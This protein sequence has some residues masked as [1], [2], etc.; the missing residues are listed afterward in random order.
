[1][2]K[3]LT[4]FL[5]SGL[6]LAGCHEVENSKEETIMN[7]TNTNATIY[8]NRQQLIVLKKK[9]PGFYDYLS[10]DQEKN[11]VIPGLLKTKT[12]K[13]GR[14]S[15]SEEM[16]PQ[17]V[18]VAG[19]YL[20]VS[21]YSRDHQHNSVLYVLDR[22]TRNYVKTIVLEGQPHVGGITFDPIHSN[23]WITTVNENK[24]KQV[25]SAQISA[26]SLEE[27]ER[28]DF[29]STKRPIHYKFQVNLGELPEASFVGYSN[30]RLYIGLFEVDQEGVLARYS[31]EKDGSIGL[32]FN[33]Q[34]KVLA[35]HYLPQPERL[36]TLP[37]KIQGIAFYDDKIVLS[38][39]YGKANSKLLVYD[40]PE[41][42]NKLDLDDHP[43]KTIIA[44]PYMEQIT[45]Y[46]GKLYLIFESA[47][48]K[49]RKD[50]T[51][52]HVD[53]VLELNAKK[54]LKQPKGK[55][56]AIHEKTKRN[57]KLSKHETKKKKKSVK[58]KKGER[59]EIKR[60][61]WKKTTKRQVS[62]EK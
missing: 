59:T 38:Q 43:V 49:Y 50:K 52:T 19:E 31:I 16:D 40:D 54:T 42:K 3:Y 46:Q 30:E 20:I 26:I 53:R 56:P 57:Q 22:K 29:S 58:Y 18:G 2:K 34:V 33:H 55:K 62:Y 13:N 60:K 28:Y 5:L 15:T 41:K 35:R 10:H 4:V 44:P 11:F 1:M 27:M 7:G 21:A 48:N 45:G 37:D 32:N 14:A 47:T 25:K 12:I 36:Y 24:E 51:I 61:E 23:L 8:T 17:G 39:S 9:Y 6:L